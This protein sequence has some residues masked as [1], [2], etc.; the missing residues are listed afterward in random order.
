MGKGN[1]RQLDPSRRHQ[2]RSIAAVHQQGRQNLG[3]RLY[4]RGDLGNC[5]GKREK[6]WFGNDRTA[7]LATD[8]CAAVPSGRRRVGKNSIPARSCLNPDDGA[9]PRMQAAFPRCGQRSH[10]S[11]T[12][13]VIMIG[14]AGGI[15]TASRLHRT[16]PA[17][18]A[19]VGGKLVWGAAQPAALDRR[20]RLAYGFAQ[21]SQVAIGNS[22]YSS[23]GSLETSSDQ[24][25]T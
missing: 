20:G 3:T 19:P 6:L 15:V 16:N 17:V 14:V 5:K 21:S 2:C 22:R 4:A 10:W 13:C 8:L 1:G 25:K 9:I 7:R 23:L 18:Q 11:G 12:T 24:R